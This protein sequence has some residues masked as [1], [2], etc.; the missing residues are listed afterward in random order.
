M[1]KAA[2]S[3]AL[4][5]GS[6]RT[7]VQQRVRAA[8]VVGEPIC[9]VGGDGE[10]DA[11]PSIAGVKQVFAVVWTFHPQIDRALGGVA[12][13][14]LE[15]V[16][17][18]I[19]CVEARH[20]QPLREFAQLGID[21]IEKVQRHHPATMVA[22]CVG[23]RVAPL[24]PRHAELLALLVGVS[25]HVLLDLSVLRR[26]VST[27]GDDRRHILLLA[28]R[29]VDGPD[30]KGEEPDRRD[31]PDA[32]EE[33][34][35]LVPS[36]HWPAFLSPGPPASS[37]AQR[38]DFGETADCRLATDRNLNPRV[39]TSFEFRVSD[40]SLLNRWAQVLSSFV[41]L[42]GSRQRQDP[43]ASFSLGRVGLLD[44]NRQRF[45]RRSRL[46]DPGTGPRL[47]AI[48][49][50]NPSPASEPGEAVSKGS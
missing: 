23:Q 29:S 44:E 32:S 36:L 49:R 15:D 34:V 48:P 46:A 42:D 6:V 38:A 18:D 19:A 1:I 14:C 31:E 10:P 17:A 7:G 13:F 22:S 30:G 47:I 28:G 39:G 25:P 26:C 40:R 33:T 50:K 27:I 5:W 3:A 11:R 16:L 21:M 9:P 35:I 24:Q 4:V 12:S 37:L 2:S 45:P 20:A 43:E 8:E 41:K